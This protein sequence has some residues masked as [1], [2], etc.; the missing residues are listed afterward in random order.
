[1]NNEDT[2]VEEGSKPRFIETRQGIAEIKKHLDKFNK[3]IIFGKN[4][5]KL[6]EKSGMTKKA[7]SEALGIIPQQYY[8]Y[9]QGI[10]EPGV[11]LA[12]KLAYIFGVDVQDLLIGI[13]DK[14]ER[15]GKLVR[16][17]NEFGVKAT[18]NASGEISIENMIWNQTAH[19]PI[20]LMEELIEACLEDIEPNIKNDFKLA[21]QKNFL[22]MG[23]SD[24]KSQD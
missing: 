9:E 2:T 18:I 22:S 15:S 17:L 20:D 12:S 7:V 4:L 14:K 8:R 13:D 11:L 1:M 16:Q 19:I 5:K 3:M 21:L 24:L 6:R 10:S 23:R